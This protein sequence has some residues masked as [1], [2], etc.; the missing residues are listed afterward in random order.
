MVQALFDPPT[1]RQ[2]E[3]EWGQT[4]Q[5]LEAQLN[6]D[7]IGRGWHFPVKREPLVPQTAPHK[8]WQGGRVAYWE[9]L[10]LWVQVWQPLPGN[11]VQQHQVFDQLK[12]GAQEQLAR[13]GRSR[14]RP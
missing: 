13:W 9:R 10:Q 5:K 2:T 3:L 4:L 8:P 7:Q 11:Q 1:A 6:M 12:A 14:M